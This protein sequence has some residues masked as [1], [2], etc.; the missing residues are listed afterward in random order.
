MWAVYSLPK[1]DLRMLPSEQEPKKQ[2]PQFTH[3]NKFS[4]KNMNNSSALYLP[5]L[6]VSNN[7]FFLKKK[8]RNK[9]HTKV[10]NSLWAVG[11]GVSLE[12]RKPREQDTASSTLLSELPR[13]DFCPM[14]DHQG[15]PLLH[16]KAESN[17]VHVDGKCVV[18]PLRSAITPRCNHKITMQVTRK[19]GSVQQRL[20]K[21][22]RQ[23]HS[24]RC[25]IG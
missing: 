11:K 2:R 21:L 22:S 1:L 24:R 15:K 5:Q 9:V 4:T 19:N 6:L 7:L 3:R 13:S 16:L 8:G 18:T 25:I 12:H 14:Y 10:I 20:R 23:K 17:P